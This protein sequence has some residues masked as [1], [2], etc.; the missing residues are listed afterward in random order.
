MRHPD[1]AIAGAVLRRYPSR[2]TAKPAPGPRRAR[3]LT[4][5]Q[6]GHGIVHAV[7]Q[8]CCVVRLGFGRDLD[9]GGV[10]AALYRLPE[11]EVMRF[12]PGQHLHVDLIYARIG[13]H[14]LD[15][16]QALSHT[17]HT[18]CE[19]GRATEPHVHVHVRAPLAIALDEKRR[20]L[21]SHELAQPASP[22]PEIEISTIALIEIYRITPPVCFQRFVRASVRPRICLLT[23]RQR[24]QEAVPPR[25][26]EAPPRMPSGVHLFGDGSQRY[27]TRRMR[28]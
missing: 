19:L 21:L 14:K 5:R 8:R 1:N 7:R 26:K 28:P 17:A 9:V 18:G 15:F 22:H 3:R 11:E 20:L 23:A 4:I 27:F 13:R 6:H 12:R 25:A 10:R 2:G 24:D 16:K